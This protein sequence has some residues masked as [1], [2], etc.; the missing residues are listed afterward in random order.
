MRKRHRYSKR[1]PEGAVVHFT[2]GRCSR[3]DADA[4]A[5]I[6]YG[7]GQGH[8]YFCISTTGKVY[9]TIPMD[10]WGSHAGKSAYTGLGS[11]VSRRTV[12]IEVC[13]AGHVKK[14]SNG[15][16]PWWNKDNSSKNDYFREDEVRH[17]ERQ[18]NIGTT[19]YYHC[20]TPEQEESLI[21]LLLW[22]HETAPSIFKIDYVVGHDEVSPGR[23]SDPGGS[24]SMTMPALREELYRRLAASVPLPIQRPDPVAISPPANQPAPSPAVA[25]VDTPVAAASPQPVPQQSPVSF[26][27]DHGLPLGPRFADLLTAYV[28]ADITHPQLKDISFAQWAHET[29]Y[30]Q[31][32]LAVT[33]N[34]Y[35][36]MKWRDQMAPLATKVYYRPDHDPKDTD[37]C[38]FDTLE[39]FIKGYWHRLDIKALP[40]A[41]KDGGWKNHAQSG[42]TFIDF[43]GPIWAP[44]G[45]DNSPLNNK[46][47]QK[48]KEVRDKLESVGLLPSL[49]QAGRDLLAA[50]TTQVASANPQIGFEGTPDQSSHL[51]DL[52]GSIRQGEWQSIGKHVGDAA[53]AKSPDVLKVLGTLE[54]AGAF[55]SLAASSVESRAKWLCEQIIAAAEPPEPDGQL[56]AQHASEF[57]KL[58]SSNAPQLDEQLVIR[59]L[60]G[61]RNVRA[62]E[63]LANLGDRL[64]AL[65][66]SAPTVRRLAAQGLIELGLTHAAILSLNEILKVAPSDHPEVSD[67]IGL[68]GRA[69]KQVF[70]DATIA[71]NTTRQPSVVRV[72]ID[73]AVRKYEEAYARARSIPNAKHN[74][75]SYPAI[76]LI[77]L[78]LRAKRDGIKVHSRINPSQLVNE[79]LADYG[80]ANSDLGAWDMATLGEAHLAK[81]DMSLDAN[82]HNTA[83]H[84]TLEAKALLLSYAKHGDVNP[85]QLAGTIR[86][87]HE[88]WGLRSGQGD[89]DVDEILYFLNAQLLA[90]EGGQIQVSTTERRALYQTG[91]HLARPQGTPEA[92]LTDGRPLP[93]GWFQLGL[94]RAN[95]VGLIK[96]RFLPP[97]LG[98]GF[99]TGFLV[100]AG[101]FHK[102]FGD[103]IALLTNSHVI[104]DRNHELNDR[105][106]PSS[107]PSKAKV[108]FVEAGGDG[109]PVEARLG[110]VI[111]DSPRGALDA[112]LIELQ[113]LPD[114]INPLPLSFTPPT[115][116]KTRVVIIGHPGGERDLRISLFETPLLDV[117]NE[118]YF[119]KTNGKAGRFLHYNNPTT[120]GSSGSPVFEMEKWEILGLHHAGPGQEAYQRWR[121]TGDDD[122]KPA[123]EGIH[124]TSI[125][126]AATKAGG[127]RDMTITQASVPPGYEALTESTSIA[128]DAGIP[129][130]QFKRVQMQRADGVSRGIV[131]DAT[132][133]GP[134][135]LV[136]DFPRDMILNR[137]TSVEIKVAREVSEKLI[138]GMR[139]DRFT[140][141]DIVATGAMTIRLRSQ[142]DGFQIEPEGDETKWLDRRNGQLTDVS[143]WRWSVTPLKSGHHKLFLTIQGL[144]FRDGIQAALPAS[145]QVIPVHVTVSHIDRAKSISRWAFLMAAGGAISFA[146]QQIFEVMIK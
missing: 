118:G 46:Y 86:Q 38:G 144:E 122:D 104:S 8:A 105:R 127:K 19:G 132:H 35:A 99:G 71:P 40:Y 61:L 4:V 47:V 114:T 66:I 5:T 49:L 59:A 20:Y 146:G 3:G 129:T 92:F 48:V 133:V 85:F 63:A 65:G 109:T 37:Y 83:R 22:M 9:Q 44:S 130:G 13:N 142:S 41:N 42:D 16:E 45:G 52:L 137:A 93:L 107:H 116:T 94:Y 76:N 102:D 75:W 31:S 113:G 36:G 97:G 141:H 131:G 79:L 43:I 39:D 58:I 54:A 68:A 51:D 78:L 112:C 121:E 33:H 24:L 128:A 7:S 89:S 90:K 1:W 11:S 72:A 139:R 115:P 23:K 103:R 81:R 32:P 101:D 6:K 18:A 110:N 69:Y 14:T 126:D 108:E 98:E 62:F 135:K 73:T 111:W 88:V 53:V 77:A 2:A 124:I 84:H 21:R 12:G 30:G 26:P 55:E 17:V 15:F 80:A 28:A 82:N 87:L 125:V 96:S 120:G 74:E 123:N 29:G 140:M 134:G 27:T 50:T 25:P 100:R 136:E 145:K 34:N 143:S 70:C 138:A 95:S 117:V 60:D 57:M 64:I 91:A 67:S 119:D 56:A 10:H 106:L